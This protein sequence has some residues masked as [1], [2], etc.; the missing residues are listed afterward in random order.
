MTMTSQRSIFYE[1]EL[2]KGVDFKERIR[3]W[4]GENLRERAFNAYRIPDTG[5]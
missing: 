3:D 1:K 4:V 2:Q 5:V